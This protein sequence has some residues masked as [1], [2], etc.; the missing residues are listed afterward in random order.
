MLLASAGAVVA[1]IVVLWW[2]WPAPPPTPEERVRAAHE[3]IRGACAT[4]DFGRV[5]D[6][7]AEARRAEI[8]S[9]LESMPIEVCE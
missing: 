9:M 7:L 4:S 3:G 5:W 8:R 1:A 6:L 2:A